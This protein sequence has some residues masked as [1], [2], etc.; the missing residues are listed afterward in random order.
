MWKLRQWTGGMTDFV[1][2]YVYGRDMMGVFPLFLY[3]FKLSSKLGFDV[4]NRN[5][6]VLEKG[7]K[8]YIIV[9]FWVLI[10]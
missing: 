7:E 1:Q 2:K 9:L 3:Y 6:M 8:F 4:R 5:V 10:A